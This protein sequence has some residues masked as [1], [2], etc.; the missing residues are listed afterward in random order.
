LLF[1]ASFFSD[2]VKKIFAWI[3]P[4]HDDDVR[5]VPLVAVDETNDPIVEARN[6]THQ[7]YLKGYPPAIYLDERKKWV[8]KKLFKQAKFMNYCIIHV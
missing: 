1:Q 4:L 2:E 3:R 7:A 5:I 8:L 6:C